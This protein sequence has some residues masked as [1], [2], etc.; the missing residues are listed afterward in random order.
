MKKSVMMLLVLA[1]LTAMGTI[2]ATNDISA[3][4]TKSAVFSNCYEL[5][6]NNKK[7]PANNTFHTENEY[8]KPGAE[9]ST[10]ANNQQFIL[11]K[12]T[13]KGYSSMKRSSYL[14]E[15]MQLV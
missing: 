14:N 2:Q 7:A 13:L 8:K 6:I 3:K 10:L 15:L 4:Q 9:F 5:N 1:G 11:L 12:K